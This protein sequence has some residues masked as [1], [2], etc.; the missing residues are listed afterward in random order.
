MLSNPNGYKWNFTSFLRSMKWDT[1]PVLWQTGIMEIKT[2]RRHWQLEMG[3]L[4]WILSAVRTMRLIQQS[5]IF[6]KTKYRFMGDSSWGQHHFSTRIF[7]ILDIGSI[8]YGC[9]END[10]YGITS[11]YNRWDIAQ[12][13][14]EN[15]VWKNE[16]QKAVVL[17]D[18]N[19]L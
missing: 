10:F 4:R 14:N 13:G 9:A 7:S 6:A 2:N 8:L 5:E 17:P 3:R 16:N 15:V 1:L 11:G 12:T 18:E 19:I